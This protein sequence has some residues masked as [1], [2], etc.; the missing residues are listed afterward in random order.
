MNTKKKWRKS[1]ISWPNTTF[2]RMKCATRKYT[3][4]YLIWYFLLINIL[5]LWLGTSEWV[6]W[7]D[8]NITREFFLLSLISLAVLLWFFMMNLDSIHHEL[9]SSLRNLV[10]KVRNLSPENPWEELNINTLSCDDEL[11]EVVTA[12]NKKSTQIQEY[13]DHL[14][15][16]IGYLWHEINTPLSVIQLCIGRIKKETSH[17]D[18]ELIE[19]EIDQIHRLTTMIWLLVS[20]IQPEPDD[21]VSLEKV[22]WKILQEYKQLY[23]SKN[24]VYKNTSIHSIQSNQV[25]IYTIVRNLVDNAIMHW[26][27]DVIIHSSNSAITINDQWKWIDQALLSKIRLPFW[28]EDVSRSKSWSY[29]LWLSLVKQLC[30]QINRSV[31][32]LSEE[33]KWTTFTL[34]W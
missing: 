20:W 6:L 13:I 21:T 23:P 31:T 34:S 15:Q 25:S 32:V 17:N 26:S 24:I 10:E 9:T 5:H 4:L 8:H 14:N 3:T 7:S 18:I 19:D 16:L 1:P 22:I 27:W 30:K 12:I 29:W 33:W 28:K 11:Y 2:N